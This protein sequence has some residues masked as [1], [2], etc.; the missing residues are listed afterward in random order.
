MGTARALV[1]GSGSWL[2]EV[3]CCKAVEDAVEVE[4]ITQHGAGGSRNEESA[5]WSLRWM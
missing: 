3:S 2:E 4:R 1:V 5:N